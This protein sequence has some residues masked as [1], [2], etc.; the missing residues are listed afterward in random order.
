MSWIEGKDTQR[1]IARSIFELM[2]G[3]KR[4]GCWLAGWLA[5]RGEFVAQEAKSVLRTLELGLGH[6]LDKHLG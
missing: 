1:M 2:V 5:G 3:D 4:K 6:G